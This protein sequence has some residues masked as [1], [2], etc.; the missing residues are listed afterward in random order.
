MDDAEACLVHAR[1]TLC[2][3][4]LL[5]ILPFELDSYRL[6]V[7]ARRNSLRLEFVL[8]EPVSSSLFAT[9]S[10]PRSV[11]R[12]PRSRVENTSR[13]CSQYTRATCLEI[14]V[15]V[16]TGRWSL[17][18]GRLLTSHAAGG[19]FGEYWTASSRYGS[20]A[21]RSLGVEVTVK[22]PA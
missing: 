6:L 13:Y 5:P 11:I 15:R 9:G 3:L 16:R 10:F 4:R 8:L 12:F 18:L 14:S 17:E 19:L 2:P 20:F 7:E 21:L 22:P 1:R